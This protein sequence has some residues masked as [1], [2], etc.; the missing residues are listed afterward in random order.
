MTKVDGT[1]RSLPVE[2]WIDGVGRVVRL[3]HPAGDGGRITYDF[4]D[5]GVPAQISEPPPAEVKPV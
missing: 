5:F 2:V 1:S 4:F 3:R